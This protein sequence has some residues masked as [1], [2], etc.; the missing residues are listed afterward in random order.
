MTDQYRW[1]EVSGTGVSPSDTGTAVREA[2]PQ[3]SSGFVTGARRRPSWWAHGR[4]RACGVLDGTPQE[5]SF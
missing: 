4:V 5:A 2:R 3:S 1:N